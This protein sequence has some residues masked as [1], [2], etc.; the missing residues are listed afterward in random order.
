ME[1]LLVR[2]SVYDGFQQYLGWLEPTVNEVANR[3]SHKK[4]IEQAMASEFTKFNDLLII[5][6]HTRDSAIHLHSDVDYFAMLGKDDVT[7]GGTRVNSN[8]TLERT[9][10]AL[11]R[12]FKSTDVWI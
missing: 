12:R 11:Q 7:W 4:T 10:Q 5:G 6:S 1:R 2:R 8:T 9:K 3:K